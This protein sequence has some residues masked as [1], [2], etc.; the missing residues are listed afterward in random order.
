MRRKFR[1]DKSGKFLVVGVIVVVIIIILAVVLLYYVAADRGWYGEQDPDK[2]IG[3]IDVGCRVKYTDQALGRVAV[4]IESVQAAYTT[5]KPQ[6]M[7]F[8][9]WLNGPQHIIGTENVRTKLVFT[10]TNP[11]AGYSAGGSVEWEKNVPAWSTQYE[12]KN[13]DKPFAVSQTGLYS[14]QVQLYRWDDNSK[15]ALMDSATS[16]VMVM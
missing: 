9:E 12:D 5:E 2:I 14:V 13:A 6:T 10:V 11:A 4:E 8:W 16:T 15:W 3:R 7:G 1:K